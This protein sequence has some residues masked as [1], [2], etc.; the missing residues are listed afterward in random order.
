[1]KGPEMAMIRSRLGL[2]LALCAGLFSFSLAAGAVRAGD[3]PGWRGP[4]GTGLTDEDGKD[5]P[6]TWDG[7][8]RQNTVWKAS[9]AGTTGHSSPIVWGDRV[10]I[11]TA[12]KQTSQQEQSKEVPEH[13]LACYRASDGNLLWR[14]PIAPGKMPAGYAI[15]A[16]PTPCT[17]GEAVY[18]WFGSAVMA[19]VDFDGKLLWR[20]ER[21]GP[22][23]ENPNLLNPGICASPVLYRDTVILRLDL[24]RGSGFLQ[25]LDKKTGQVKWEQKRPNLTYCNTTGLI[26]DVKGKPQLVIAGSDLLQGLDPA[27]GEPVWWCK[28][29]A[30][31]PSPVCGSGLIYIDKGNES[32]MAVDPTGQGDVTATGV[33]WQTTKVSAEYSSP[34]VVGDCVYRST[35]PGGVLCR[36][37]S[38]GEEVYSE[39]VKGISILAS[40]VAAAGGRIY[41]ISADKSFV[42]QAGTTFNLLATNALGGGSN[43]S[44]AA[45]SRGRFFVRDG[46]S[47][48]CIG[49]K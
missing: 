35:K 45:V 27:G 17:D 7:K 12:A 43:G 47:L 44:S 46:E 40:P 30:F 25:G 28:S 24:G 38:S 3:W 23:L 10:F 42:V 16:V 6:L 37:L 33:K 14:T 31:G 15:Y 13:H 18:C 41:F 34:V 8:M 1:M 48:W 19:A 49:A 2:R 20:H 29:K 11:T 39:P 36:R 26:L 22:F 32:A 4:A 21:A 9:L 5:L